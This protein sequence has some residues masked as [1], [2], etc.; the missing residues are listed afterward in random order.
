MLTEYDLLNYHS[1]Y[2]AVTVDVLERLDECLKKFAKHP[3]LEHSFMVLQEEFEELKKE[4]YKKESER[5]NDRIY[6]EGIDLLATVFR[7]LLDNDLYK[8][9]LDFK[10]DPAN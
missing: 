6:D 5:D 10:Y 4:L 8:L 9:R 7:L 1:R 2:R 3:S